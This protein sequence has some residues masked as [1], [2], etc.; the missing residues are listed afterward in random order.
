MRHR[1]HNGAS[2]NNAETEEK[3][4][5][6]PM[7]MTTSPLTKRKNAT[8]SCCCCSRSGLSIGC[9]LVGLLFLLC[10]YFGS[11]ST[12][13]V[14][15]PSNIAAWSAHKTVVITGANSVVAWGAL[16]HLLRANTAQHIV[17]ACRSRERCDETL[18][19]AQRQVFGRGVLPRIKNTVVS[20]VSLDLT[21]RASIAQC[22]KDIQSITQQQQRSDTENTNPQ[23][24]KKKRRTMILVWNANDSVHDPIQVNGF[25]HLYLTHLLYPQLQRIV[26]AASIVGGVP[27]NVLQ[28]WNL[29]APSYPTWFQTPARYGTNKRAILFL[30]QHLVETQ[31]HRRG[32]DEDDDG[33]LQVIATQ[34]GLTCDVTDECSVLSMT[35][36][37][38]AFSHLRAMLD[39]NLPPGSYI[40]HRWV[41]WGS[42]TVAG[43]LASS[44]Y[45]MKLTKETR[46]ELWAWGMR[47]LDIHDFGAPSL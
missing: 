47:E 6:L 43:S 13:D 36:Q 7:T 30:A 24:T 31:F 44:W 11:T 40:G 39:P 45:H 15:T 3:R 28:P 9:I 5:L 21:S 26:V 17:M 18:A 25:G 42:T 37:R 10:Y 46:E 38:G 16:V 4:L 29:S 22:A 14:M 1:G 32:D 34:A 8:K 33:A 23:E 41:L 27:W 12:T 19:Q 20:T 35:P 2:S